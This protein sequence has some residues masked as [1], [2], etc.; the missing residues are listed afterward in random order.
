MH[1]EINFISL[2]A[3]SEFHI[4]NLVTMLYSHSLFPTERKALDYVKLQL[5]WIRVSICFV[6]PQKSFL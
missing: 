3:L 1:Y 4:R 5:T 6:E 2:N